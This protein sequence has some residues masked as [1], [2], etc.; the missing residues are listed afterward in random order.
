[1]SADAPLAANGPQA[2]P[3]PNP[4]PIVANGPASPPEPAVPARPNE[5]PSSPPQ[6]AAAANPSDA[7]PATNGPA[8][9]LQSLCPVQ[10]APEGNRAN[11][12]AFPAGGGPA[13][14]FGAQG[15][16]AVGPNPY[17]AQIRK[18]RR[19]RRLITA[20]VCVSVLSAIGVAVQNDAH[21]W[22]INQ[23]RQWR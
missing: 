20:L 6:V 17:L 23:F 7:A 12:F 21:V 11:P 18:R 3:V 5:A 19:R 2:P 16:G 14:A 1:K 9:A 13:N 8:G 22:A 10:A 4:A 15:E